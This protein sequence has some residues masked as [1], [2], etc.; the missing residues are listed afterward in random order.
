MSLTRKQRELAEIFDVPVSLLEAI[1]K[2]TADDKDKKKPEKKDAKGSDDKSAD[3]DDD[4][5]SPFGKDDE[6]DDED[7]DEE[8]GFAKDGEDGEE[9][10]PDAPWEPEEGDPNGMGTGELD[11]EEEEM[12]EKAEDEVAADLAKKYNTSLDQITMYP[13]TD[14]VQFTK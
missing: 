14:G 3:K 5:K 11:A 2:A 12:R 6:S 7:G 13:S 8:A 4:K 10:D 1:E 9:V